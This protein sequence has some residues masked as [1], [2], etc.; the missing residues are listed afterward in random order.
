M[1]CY[2]DIDYLVSRQDIFI[3]RPRLEDKAIDLFIFK[4]ALVN[5]AHV[6]ARIL[7]RSLY[8]ALDITASGV[9]YGTFKYLH[10]FC[11]CLETH[12]DDSGNH[13]WVR[14]RCMIGKPVPADIR[15]YNN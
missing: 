10:L 3:N 13:L 12:L 1:F 6:S 14:R 5:I 4:P 2:G 15:L 9:I 7:C 8:S 11:A